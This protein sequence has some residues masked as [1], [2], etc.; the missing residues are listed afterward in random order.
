[1]HVGA[2][3]RRPER[4]HRSTTRSTSF[5]LR[6]SSRCHP[7]HSAAIGGVSRSHARALRNIR[8]HGESSPHSRGPPRHLH[9]AK[10]AL[11]MRHQ[12]RV[13]AVGRRESGHAVRRAVGIARIRFG[14]LPAVVDRS[15]ARRAAAP[16]R[17]ARRR[18]I[19]HSLR[20]GRWRPECGC[21]PCRGRRA[22]ASAAPRAARSATR[23]ARTCC[24]RSAANAP[25]PE[26]ARDRLLIIWQPLHTPSANVSSRAKNAAK[27]SRARAL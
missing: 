4:R 3:D 8:I 11:R 6:Q 13:A 25:S 2:S 21:L 19:R 18:G 26:S 16:R 7:R 27:S 23:T 5:D 17:A 20:R 14:R 9:R 1:M 22:T 15:A 10:D 12:D 24:A